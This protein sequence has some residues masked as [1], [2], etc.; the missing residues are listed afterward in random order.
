M[1]DDSPGDVDGVQEI[2]DHPVGRQRLLLAG[3]Q[4]QPLVPPRLVL[5]ADAC[6]NFCPPTPRSTPGSFDQYV[7]QL[8]E[9]QRR[10]ADQRDLGRNVLVDVYRVNRVVDEPLA[11]PR[12]PPDAEAGLREAGAGAKDHIGVPEMLRQ[13]SGH[14]HAAGS[15]GERMALGK[16]ALT[17]QAGGYRSLKQ[18]GDFTQ[19]GP[20]LRVVH[21][22]T[23]V[24]DRSLGGEEDVSRRGNRIGLGGAPRARRWRVS[25][26]AGLLLLPYVGRHLDED[27][28]WTPG[29]RLRERAPQR[30]HYGRGIAYLLT[31]FRHVR[32]VDCRV[33]GR[34][35]PGSGPP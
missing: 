29:A 15:Q 19:L 21:S 9:A 23:C 11:V 30:R 8:S 10:I 22:L 31:P 17:F 26:L 1:C 13:G 4:G 24:D 35:H 7:S 32:E 33:E 25:E 14:G 12:G 34:L 28:P 5:L 6:L 27:R 20:C 18:F 3:Q 16:G 2:P